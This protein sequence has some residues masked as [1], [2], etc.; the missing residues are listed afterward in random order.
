MIKYGLQQRVLK[1]NECWSNFK[2]QFSFRKF[3]FEQNR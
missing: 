1:E 2:K 3:L